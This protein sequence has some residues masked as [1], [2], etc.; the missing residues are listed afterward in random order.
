MV[1]RIRWLGITIDPF[2]DPVV[3]PDHPIAG[4]RR[5][6]IFT[7]TPAFSTLDYRSRG[8]IL[9]NKEPIP[10]P[11]DVFRKDRAE[12]FHVVTEA[13]VSFPG[14]QRDGDGAVKYL[15]GT[16][17]DG[18]TGQPSWP[19]GCCLTTSRHET[20]G[21]PP[22]LV[23]SIGWLGP[24]EPTTL[25]VQRTLGQGSHRS[26]RSR[27]DSATK[28]FEAAA[29]S[30]AAFTSARFCRQVAPPAAARLIVPTAVAMVGQS[31]NLGA[32]LLSPNIFVPR[33]VFA[34]QGRNDGSPLGAEVNGNG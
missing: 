14:R 21:P 18:Q 27:I 25:S 28:A 23:S 22:A 5:I 32:Y 17:R 9:H 10:N 31:D 24:P 4:P 34:H 20:A 33:L 8:A 7:H 19:S 11:E 26:S 1:A 30:E 2:G 12:R 6:G 16:N 13:I 3:R 15:I 29:S